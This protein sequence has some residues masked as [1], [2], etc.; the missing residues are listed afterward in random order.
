M[1]SHTS[2]PMAILTAPH[3]TESFIRNNPAKFVDTEWVNAD[4]LKS[5]LSTQEVHLNIYTSYDKLVYTQQLADT[6][7]HYQFHKYNTILTTR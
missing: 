6:S 4:D 7:L 3:A 2:I 1:F 5:F